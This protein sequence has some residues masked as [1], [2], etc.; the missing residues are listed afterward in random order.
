VAAWVEEE[1]EW[2]VL[3]LIQITTPTLDTAWV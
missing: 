3:V 1:V 2:V